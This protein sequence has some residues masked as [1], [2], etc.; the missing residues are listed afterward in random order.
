MKIKKVKLSYSPG[1][2]LAQGHTAPPRLASQNCPVGLTRA[3]HRVHAWCYHCVLGAAVVDLCDKVMHT[4]MHYGDGW[5]CILTGVA[6]VN[7]GDRR[8]GDE[9]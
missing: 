1:R 4:G 3:Q 6:A 5:R 7:G 9:V 2:H 8:G